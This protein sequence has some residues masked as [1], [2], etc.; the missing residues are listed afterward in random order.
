MEADPRHGLIEN[1]DIHQTVPDHR[2]KLTQDGWK[3]VCPVH[4]FYA[5]RFWPFCDM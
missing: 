2:V 5:L 4:Y 3:Q 1:R